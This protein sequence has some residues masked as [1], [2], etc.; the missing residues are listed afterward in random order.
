M[1]EV[2][3]LRVAVVGLRDDE[4]AAAAERRVERQAAGERGVGEEASAGAASDHPSDRI[5]MQSWGRDWVGEP[6]LESSDRRRDLPG[7]CLLDCRDLP[8]DL[9]EPPPI[10]F[11]IH[12]DEGWRGLLADRHLATKAVEEGEELVVLLLGEGVVLVVVALRAAERHA[13]PG[14]GRRVG[15][16]DRVDDAK[17][18]RVGAPLL[19]VAVEP[20]E[21]RADLLHDGGVGQQVAGKRLDRELVEGHVGVKRLDDR[22]AVGMVGPV[23]VIL[24]AARIA[25]PGQV[26]PFHRE[27]L[28]VVRRGE[29]PVHGP[30]VG[31][32]GI[33]GQEGVEFLDGGRQAREVERQ[34]AQQ[35]VPRGLGGRPHVR[36]L[37]PF[38]DEGID[39]R[40][41][42][43]SVFDGRNRRPLRRA[44]R[45]VALVVSPGLDPRPQEFPRVRRQPLARVGGRHHRV[46]VVRFDPVDDRAGFEP[47]GHD[48]HRPAR[49]R[50]GGGLAIVEPQVRLASGGVW[51]V[52]GQAVFGEDRPDVTGKVGGRRGGLGGCS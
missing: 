21:S 33:V 41:H 8:V 10:L 35:R 43:G 1:G 40:P 18:L 44:K 46:G 29:Q 3:H 27:L 52:A 9:F 28:G 26:E 17:L 38:E 47:A 2:A 5:R 32:R 24:V 22:V 14:R 16:I 20:V 11:G 34:P 45:P 37:E 4:A 50:R 39:R 31:L 12:R 42:P 30:L 13:H 23:A 51:A 15:A 7:P 6:L 48:R 36:L 19:V 25:E 49:Q